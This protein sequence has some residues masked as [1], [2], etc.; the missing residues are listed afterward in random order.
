MILKAMDLGI[1]FGALDLIEGAQFQIDEG[2]KVAL[3]GPNGSGKTT[4]LKVILGQDPA[5]EQAPYTGQLV[6]RNRLRSGYQKQF[7]V[8]DPERRLWTEYEREFEDL[9]KQVEHSHNGLGME[10]D[11]EMLSYEKKIRSILKGLGFAEEDWERPLKTFSGGE[12]T[13]I[14]LGKVFL[15]D[16]DF[17]ILDEPTNHLDIPSVIWLEGMLRQYTGSIL[18]V[19]HDRELVDRVANRVFEINMKQIYVFN[20]GYQDFLLQRQR[21]NETMARRQKNLDKEIDRQQRLVEQYKIW[22]HRN[23]K[24]IKQARSREKMVEKLVAQADQIQIMDE[25]T[26]RMGAIP[27]VDRT[28]YHLVCV[29]ELSKSYGGKPVFRNVSFDLYRDEK[30][31]ILGK[32]GVGKT[33]LLR[34]LTGQEPADSGRITLGPKTKVGYLSQD[35]TELDES[36]DVLEQLWSL[37]RDWPDFEIRKYAG[38]FGFA[39]EDVFKPVSVLS[40]G[41][42]LKLALATLFLKPFN[43]LV[44]DEPT[45]HLDLPS[46]ER[47][48][49]VLEDYSGALLMVTHDRRLLRQVSNKIFFLQKNGIRPIRSLQV[50]L[51]RVDGNFR[52]PVE[53]RG[54][55]DRSTEFQQQK[56]LKNRIKSI[57][58]ELQKIEEAFAEHEGNHKKISALLYSTVDYQKAQELQ[59]QIDREDQQMSAILVRMEELEE[60]RKGLEEEME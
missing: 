46:I 56:N 17:L 19:S 41:E 47:L 59:R 21:M 12:L 57:Q 25:Q 34:I 24:F 5:M 18:M 22:G 53:N 20:T 31:V 13:R 50:Y 9:Q 45:N 2:N 37:K 28:D 48:Q 38:R 43:F 10:I 35:L 44:L 8:D 60:E 3:I 33:T 23:E 55:K 4:L 11:H 58:Q 40:G 29:E 51:D 27:T 15:R 42:K 26:T 7:R 49:E 52:Q 16:Y 14:S 30:A 39:G 1:S 6:M 54:K 36:K 32:N